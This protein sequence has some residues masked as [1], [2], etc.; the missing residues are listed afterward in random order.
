MNIS[1]EKT[2]HSHAVASLNTDHSS[3]SKKANATNLTTKVDMVE[4][5]CDAFAKM[6]ISSNKKVSFSNLTKKVDMVE[7]LCDA[8]AKMSISSNK[9]V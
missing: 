5:L 6:S 7:D 9:K 2:S 8:F 4:N 3:Q 1:A